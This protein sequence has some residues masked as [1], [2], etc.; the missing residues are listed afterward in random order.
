MIARQG[1]CSLFT[2]FATK[3]NEA[4]ETGLGEDGLAAY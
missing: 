2:G 3:S 1:V 4:S